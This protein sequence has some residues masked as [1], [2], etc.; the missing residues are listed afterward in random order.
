MSTKYEA[1]NVA[2]QGG[3]SWATQGGGALDAAR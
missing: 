1:M 3:G 2:T